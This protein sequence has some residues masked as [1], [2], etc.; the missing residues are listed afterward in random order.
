MRAGL[1]A[2]AKLLNSDE[3]LGLSYVAYDQQNLR[4]FP[5][6]NIADG[7]QSDRFILSEDRLTLFVIN[8]TDI[9]HDNYRIVI[10]ADN[11]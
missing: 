4:H 8:N 6:I 10:A 11:N 3:E 2:E 7:C 9:H 1:G 5:G